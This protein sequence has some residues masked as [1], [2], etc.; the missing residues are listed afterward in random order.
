[1][2]GST[3]LCQSRAA[4]DT[5]LTSNVASVPSNWAFTA[6]IFLHTF[7]CAPVCTWSTAG[8]EA[9][10]HAGNGVSTGKDFT[11]FSVEEGVVVFETIKQKNCVRFSRLLST[12]LLALAPIAI[13]AGYCSVHPDDIS[14]LEFGQCSTYAAIA[15]VSGGQ[16]LQVSVYPADHV[17]AQ[18][19]QLAKQPESRASRRLEAWRGVARAKK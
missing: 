3:T 19:F 10:V 2:A 8:C 6:T 12:L 18:G 15:L 17:K 11:L 9:Q 5:V 14:S 1:V 4:V 7:H 16:N 13:H